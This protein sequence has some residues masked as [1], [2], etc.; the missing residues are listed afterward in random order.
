MTQHDTLGAQPYRNAII[1][2]VCLL[3]LAF[4]VTARVTAQRPAPKPV[5]DPCASLAA[6]LQRE[7]GL[8]E[9][10][11]RGSHT[12]DARMC[13]GEAGP[14]TVTLS[15]V[16]NGAKQAAMDDEL[17]DALRQSNLMEVDREESGAIRCWIIQ[18]HPSDATR[19]PALTQCG[20]I[21][22]GT[23]VNLETRTPG[24]APMTSK[25]VRAVL[26]AVLLRL[27]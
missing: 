7:L 9:V 14:V 3:A 15:Y 13:K 21:V 23:W 8:R 19:F 18:P 5:V 11:L 26:A 17:N 6:D 16:K 10:K 27:R 25:A 4:S 12:T 22:G 2:I 24:T 1:C 20:S